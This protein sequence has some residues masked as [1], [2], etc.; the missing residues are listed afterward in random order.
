MD[1]S[2]WKVDLT[3]LLKEGNV[4]ALVFL[5]LYFLSLAYVIAQL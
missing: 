5:G 3:K 4:G 2:L 1:S